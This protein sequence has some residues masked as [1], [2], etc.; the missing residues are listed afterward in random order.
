VGLG[1]LHDGAQR[2]RIV[3]L[4]LG[5]G[6]PAELPGRAAPSAQAVSITYPV[7]RYP[8]KPRSLDLDADPVAQG[9]L[10]GI[11]G[12]Y[13]ILDTGVVNLRKYAGYEIELEVFE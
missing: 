1:Q 13:L 3:G 9:T 2:D 8:R 10:L 6:S 5:Q 7:S 4:Y 12:Q 11:K